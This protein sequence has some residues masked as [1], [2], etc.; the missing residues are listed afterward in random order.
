M[1]RK[2]L[3][4]T[5]FYYL[6]IA[7]FS[8]AQ[9][10]ENTLKLPPTLPDAPKRYAG[11]VEFGFLYGKTGSTDLSS[12]VASP[13]VQLF[14]GYR[15]HRMFV[16]GGTLGMDFYDNVLITPIALG[17]RGELFDSR[18]SPTYGLDLGYSATFLSDEDEQQNHDGGWMFSPS[19][20][21][22]VQTGNSTAFTFGVGYKAQKART[23]TT[24]W[25]GGRAEQKINYKRLS[26]RMGFMF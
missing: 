19:A 3:L 9:S 2:S 20:G 15:F 8:T 25:G 11:M 21:I 18:V 1:K 6:V 16:L 13:T 5:L 23:E 14:S 26:L 7:G 12:S 10:Q 4:L 24:W 22:S 17:L